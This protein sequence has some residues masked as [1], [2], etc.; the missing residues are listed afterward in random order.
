VSGRTVVDACQGIDLAAWGDAGWRVR[1]L[2]GARTA[3]SRGNSATA[4]TLAT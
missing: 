3:P 1:S 2:T 4:S